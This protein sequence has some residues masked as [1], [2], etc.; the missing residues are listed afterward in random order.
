M[1]KEIIIHLLIIIEV[2]IMTII[3]EVLLMTIIIEVFIMTIIIEIT[4]E[5]II[6]KIQDIITIGAMKI[7][8][9]IMMVISSYH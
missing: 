1:K 5:I 4:I 3:I 9:I 7:Q 2:P 8:R 6:I